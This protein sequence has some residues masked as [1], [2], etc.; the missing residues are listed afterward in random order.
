VGTTGSWR[1]R[2]DIPAAISGTAL[3]GFDFPIG[4]PAAYARLAGIT[5]FRDALTNFGTGDWQDFYNVCKSPAEISL[6]RPF[7]PNSC[8]LPGACRRE[9]LTTALG[10]QW[11]D[12]YRQCERKTVDRRAA[13]PLFWTLGGNQVGKASLSGWREF[14]QPIVSQ[15]PDV[16]L[17]P[18]DGSLVDLL[19]S[20]SCVIVETYP[21]EFYGYLGVRFPGGKNGGKRSPS[22]RTQLAVPLLA[23]TSAVD[24]DLSRA[25]HEA[26]T[27]GLGSSHDGEDD[28]DAMVGLLGI[29][30]H[31]RAGPVTEPPLDPPVGSVE[32]WIFAQ[33]AARV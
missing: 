16:G 10:M 32:G 5:S 13:C 6:H 21:R 11:S 2:L 15:G 25:A 17:W 9:H 27:T 33:K 14:V 31:L 18:F 24:A 29:L 28:F 20:R 8:P 30:K 22:A 12:L 3:V 4:V 19:P 1:K 7:F 23:A 26:V